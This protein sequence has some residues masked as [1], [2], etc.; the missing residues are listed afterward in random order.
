L[1]SALLPELL[2]LSVHSLG[3]GKYRGPG[4]EEKDKG[5]KNDKELGYRL[6]RWGEINGG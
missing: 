2:K 1:P 4:R 5:V 3:V 6:K